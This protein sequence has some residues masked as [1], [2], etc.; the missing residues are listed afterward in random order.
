MNL[1]DEVRRNYPDRGPAL[2]A[3]CR[4]AGSAPYELLEAISRARIA[5]ARR[6]GEHRTLRHHA[7]GREFRAWAASLSVRPRDDLADF[8]EED[9][10]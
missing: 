2:Q 5:G 7:G 3:G 1:L 6:R 8:A 4:D 9:D 10:E